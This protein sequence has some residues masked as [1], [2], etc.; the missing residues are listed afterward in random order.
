MG[1]EQNPSLVVHDVWRS[2]YGTEYIL[3]SSKSIYASGYR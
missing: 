1:E 2:D 3:Q